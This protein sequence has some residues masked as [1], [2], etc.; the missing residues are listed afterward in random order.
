MKISYDLHIHSTLSA[1][2]DILQSP[3]NILNMCMLKG[4][5]MIAITDHNTLAHLPIFDRLKDGYN[6]LFLYGCEVTV[7]E[8]FHVLIYFDSLKKA[9]IFNEY[10][11]NKHNKNLLLN[12]KFGKQIL[13]D[14]FDEEVNVIP[15]ALNYSMDLPYNNLVEIVRNLDGIIIL[16]HIDHKK[17]GVLTYIKSIKNL[18]FD[19]IEIINQSL[20]LKHH[21]YLKKYRILKNSDAHNLVDINE[22]VDFIELEHLSFNSFKKYLRSKI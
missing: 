18:E 20:I 3:N 1:C 9:S 11:S 6:F 15:Y 7:K 2:A 21:P 12:E 5:D 19:G 4:L 13:C 16:A 17:N 10:I 14:I 22:N 8:G